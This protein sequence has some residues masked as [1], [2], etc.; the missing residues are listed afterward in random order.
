MKLPFALPRWAWTATA[1]VA[2]L[3]AFG[4]VATTS[5]PL[6]PVKVTLTQAA[7][8]TVT[9]SLFGIGTV[10]ARRAYLIGPTVAG[11][12]ERVL[13]DVGDKVKAGQLLAEMDAVDLDARVGS[14]SAAAARARS[15]VVTAQAQVHDARSRQALA[16]G[17]AHRY[18]DLGK[19]NFVS[20]SVVDAKLQLQQSA[21]AQLAAAESVHAGARQDVTRLEAERE[22][23]R[24][25]RGNFRLEAPVD[26]VVTSRD[27]E[28]GSTVVAGQAV[29]K[30][31]DPASLWVTTRF[32]QSR[33]AGLRA[34][35]P[36]RI[37]LRSSGVRGAASG[38]VVRLDPASDSVTEERIAQVAFD[39]LP[40]GVST[41]EMAEVL[42]SLPA[43]TGALLIPNAALRQRGAQ[44]GVWRRSDGQLRFVSVRTGAEGADGMVQVIEGLKAGD[45]VVVHSERELSAASRIRVVPALIET[46]R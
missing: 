8:G 3:L 31:I 10:E 21:D 24:Q 41:G 15:A 6:A 14:S 23:A 2:V 33:S 13:V 4:W 39:S 43:V 44:S 34:G 42:V 12:V 16:S 7:T 37:T 46:T 20:S 45:E 1:G 19:Q 36:G 11:R 27:A 40:L 22:G 32:D 30:L 28:P 17:E 18:I 26:G 35:L 9:P 5:G 38:K 25:Q 29:L